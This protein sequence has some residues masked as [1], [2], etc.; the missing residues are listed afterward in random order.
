MRTR[1]TSGEAGFALILALLTLMLLTFLGLTLATTTSTELQIATN[2]RWSQAAWY[3]AEA[4]IE[5]GK[6][7]L[8][9]QEWQTLLP[10]ARP[11]PIPT[12]PYTPTAASRPTP[13]Q[14]RPGPYNEAS[15]NFEG[16]DC[17]TDQNQGYGVVLDHP[18][19]AYPFQNIS[20]YLGQ[21]LNGSFTLWIRRDFSQATSID[22]TRNDMLYLTAEG[23]APFQTAVSA[24]AAQNRAIRYIQFKLQRFIPGDCENRAAQ[25][26]AG[27]TGAGFDQ[28]DPTQTNG[29]LGGVTEPGASVK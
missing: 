5:I 10:A 27:P 11:S 24:F 20:Q 17:D 9:Q 6:R 4:G 14:S 3:N 22:E 15:R 13:L 8:R 26:G 21:T 1:A 28:C 2:Y 16:W 12:P 18:T 25:Q 23:T 29:I 19:L 7:F